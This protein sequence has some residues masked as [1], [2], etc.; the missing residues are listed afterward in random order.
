ML[1]PHIMYSG[2]HFD[3]ERGRSLTKAVKSLLWVYERCMDN[4][5]LSS[6]A[7]IPILPSTSHLPS[8]KKK[9]SHFLFSVLKS[10]HSFVSFLRF[11]PS[12]SFCFHRHGAPAILLSIRAPHFLH[13]FLSNRNFAPRILSPMLAIQR[14]LQRNR[15]HSPPPIQDPA[16]PNRRHE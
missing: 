13:A 11:V 5:S 12:S 4:I 8:H 6:N 9:S 1:V 7:R 16:F 10:I 15:H 3:A 2:V 14:L